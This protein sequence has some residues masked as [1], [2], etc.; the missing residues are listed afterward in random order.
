MR[1][2]LYKINTAKLLTALAILLAA[3]FAALPRTQAQ[4]P[5]P[6]KNTYVNDHAQL[7]TPAQIETLNQQIFEI[8]QQTNVQLAVVI[9]DKMPPDYTIEEY[10]RQIGRVWQVGNNK[11]GLVY[12][13]AIK[14]HKQRLQAAS[15]L[16]DVFTNEKCSQI[17]DS[18]KPLYKA[19]DYYAGLQ[20][21][22]GQVQ[23]ALLPA[24][25]PIEQPIQPQRM[26]DSA[27]ATGNSPG[28]GLIIF[29]VALGATVLLAFFNAARLTAPQNGNRTYN[30][31]GT[32]SSD[33]AVQ[34]AGYTTDGTHTH[35]GIGNVIAGAAAGVV[36]GSL[37]DGM[38]NNH[39]HTSSNND[40][41]H[42]GSSHSSSS[43][44]DWGNWGSSSSSSDSSS[45]SGGSSSYDSG[46][47]SSADSGSGSTGATGDW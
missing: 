6:A 45:Y 21:L 46:G 16:A 39:H 31:S 36:A 30:N 20:T 43:S 35:S 24:S 44:S 40:D 32:G 3:M 42:N 2:L 10:A 7:L 13:A 28:T 23:A 41:R 26:A 14:Q 9:V 4:V 25:A 34:G 8:E 29:F 37:L 5:A 33:D 15:G 47:F 18:V 17:L 11:N 38:L 27:P 12:V 19:R 1:H 22:V